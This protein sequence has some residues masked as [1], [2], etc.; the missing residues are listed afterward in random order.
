MPAEDRVWRHDGRELHQ[1]FAAEYFSFDRQE[2][3]LVIG[4]KDPFLAKLLEESRAV[5]HDILQ[6]SARVL[7]IFS[8]RGAKFKE[9]SLE[10]AP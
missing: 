4:Q 10:F 7:A 6:F 2:P 3:P 9:F 8:C 5:R 1:G